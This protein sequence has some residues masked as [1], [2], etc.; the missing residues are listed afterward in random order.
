MLTQNSQKI[1]KKFYCKKCDYYANRKSDYNKHLQTKK[2]NTY[3][4]LQND[5]PKLFACICGKKYKHRQSL[6]NHKKKCINEIKTPKNNTTIVLSKNEN[7]PELASMFM[8][9]MDTNKELQQIICKQNEKLNEQNEK[10]IELAKQ[11]RIINNIE[12]QNNFNLHNFLN[13]E[14]KDN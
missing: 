1:S 4:D 11:P 3:I 9:L 13:V 6:N 8:K 10:L 5:L 2:H 7:Q 12:K 14:C